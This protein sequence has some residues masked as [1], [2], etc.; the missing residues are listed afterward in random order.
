[1]KTKKLTQEKE[2]QRQ[3]LQ[4]AQKAQSD[5]TLHLEDDEKILYR[6]SVDTPESSVA[7]MATTLFAI[8]GFPFYIIIGFTALTAYLSE[9][10]FAEFTQEITGPL[11]ILAAVA[12][13]SIVL[14]L[15]LQAAYKS[16]L[17][18]NGAQ[19]LITNKRLFNYNPNGFMHVMLESR[20][21]DVL[22]IYPEKLGKQE[23]LQVRVKELEV[24]ESA[25]RTIEIRHAYP[26]RNASMAFMQIPDQ[27]R[28]ERSEKS[29]SGALYKQKTKTE[30]ALALIGLS[31]IICFLAFVIVTAS[32]QVAVENLLQDGRQLIKA[33]QFAQAERVYRDAYQKIRAFPFHADFG[34]AAYRYAR[35]LETN[36]K[37]AQCVPI[38]RQ[39]IERCN[40]SDLEDNITWKPAVFRSNVHLAEIYKQEKN[41]KMA[42]HYFDKALATANFETDDKRIKSLISSYQQFLNE[43]SKV[44]KAAMIDRLASTFKVNQESIRTFSD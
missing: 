27:V 37:L 21:P 7:G 36:G 2:Q 18:G 42:E 24:S 28:L 11:G 15:A 1:M 25:S 40:W 33:G 43:H 19:F 39:A 17:G 38:Y 12:V 13:F 10:T 9:K 32:A 20:Y 29:K 41:D 3:A 6:E 22:Y 23:Y 26:V 44:G 35:V 31:A 16:T 34:P 30:A 14:G 8:F 5:S 4:S